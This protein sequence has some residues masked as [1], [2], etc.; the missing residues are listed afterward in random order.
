MSKKRQFKNTGRTQLRFFPDALPRP[1][2]AVDADVVN[3][4]SN[5]RHALLPPEINETLRT[6]ADRLS[7]AD[8]GWSEWDA[9]CD[10]TARWEATAT[11]SDRE[12][13]R[14]DN[15]FIKGLVRSAV[16]EGFW[17]AL[18]RYATHLRGSAEATAFIEGR[19]AGLQ[20]GHDS[21]AKRSAE[22][23]RRIRDKWAAMEA[24]GE[25]V[26]NETVAAAMRADGVHCSRS[27][28]IRAFKPRPS[29]A[30][31]KRMPRR[32]P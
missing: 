21:Q 28:V 22:L 25:K 31:A 18:Q 27:T 26:T 15:E 24:A 2:D 19:K 17:L 11:A 20:K 23:H 4:A 9:Y 30:P 14:E 29:T 16:E 12:Q 1:A 13:Q 7:G 8:V 32:R 10:R 3:A 6:A 5:G